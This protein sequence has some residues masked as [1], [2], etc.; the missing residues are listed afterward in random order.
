MG[1]NE[2]YKKREDLRRVDSTDNQNRVQKARKLIFEQ[3]YAIKSKQVENI[4]KY[5]SSVPTRV[6]TLHPGS[7]FLTLLTLHRMLF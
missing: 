3:G 2:D 5:D 4:L 1:T 7:R 6:C